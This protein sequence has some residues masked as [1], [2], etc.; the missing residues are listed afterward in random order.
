MRRWRL[1]LIL[2]P[3]LAIGAVVAGY[4]YL[5]SQDPAMLR[6]ELADSLAT[7]LGREVTIDGTLTFRLR[8]L[9]AVAVTGLH[10]GNPEWAH[11]E[12]LLTVERLDLVP[13]IPALLRGRVV[14]HRLELEGLA[15]WLENGPSGTP[16]WQLPPRKEDPSATPMRL[17]AIDARDVTLRYFNSRTGVTRTLELDAL[18][19]T[20]KRRTDPLDIQF[21]GEIHSL[22]LTGEA[23]LDLSLIHI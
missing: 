22:A 14:I 8:P 7:A 4:A 1:I 20:G 5:R 9:P 6:D 15:L 19:A 11:Q 16:N 12:Q 2:L 10:I 13:S 18:R 3:L 21:T 17:Q 23:T